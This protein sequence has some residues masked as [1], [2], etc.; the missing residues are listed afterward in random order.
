MPSGATWDAFNWL[1]N[2]IGEMTY[3]AIAPPKTNAVAVAALR[4]GFE[5][6]ARDQDFEKEMVAKQ[7]VPYSHI[8]AEQGRAIFRAL[9]D[10]SPGVAATLRESTRGP[11]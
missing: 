4:K 9:A 2:Q 8:G 10:V 7:G 3:I 5:G 1:T 6:L 11:K